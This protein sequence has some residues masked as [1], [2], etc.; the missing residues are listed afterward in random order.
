MKLACQEGLVPGKT[1]E[2]KLDNLAVW[3]YEGVEL[4]GSGLQDRIAH[5][6]A[7]IERHQVRVSTICAGFRGSLLSADRAE[8]AQAISDIRMLLEMAGRLHAVG[9]IAVPIFGQ[10]R[11]NDLSPWKSAVELEEEL[12]VALWGPLAEHAHQH[13]TLLL[14]EPLNRYETHFIRRLEQGAAILDR[15]NMPGTALMADFFHMS[16]E[17]AD[18]SAALRAN[19]RYIAHI[20]LADSNRLQPGAGHTDFR[21]GF[22]TLKECGYQGYMALECGVQGPDRGATLAACARYLKEMMA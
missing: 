14:L 21:S 12:L 19:A 1:F 11:L 15:V 22:A 17:E 18:I 20:H 3:G 9:L 16:I 2:E 5:I 10:P 13:G 4:S 7:A 8:R 6:E